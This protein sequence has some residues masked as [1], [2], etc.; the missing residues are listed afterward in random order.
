VPV[1]R[2]EFGSGTVGEDP[3]APD[4]DEGVSWR[5]HAAHDTTRRTMT[6][7]LDISHLHLTGA[8]LDPNGQNANETATPFARGVTTGAIETRAWR[9]SE[10]PGVPGARYATSFLP[11]MRASMPT[12]MAAPRPP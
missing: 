8:G 10:E 11:G 7:N 12:P 6:K 2:I 1:P 5:S 9:D 4:G 3:F